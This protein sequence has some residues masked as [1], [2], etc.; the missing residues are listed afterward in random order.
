MFALFEVQQLC[1]V[2]LSFVWTLLI[3]PQTGEQVNPA[4]Q[5]QAGTAFSFEDFSQW[6]MSVSC[7]QSR[8]ITLTWCIVHRAR[9]RGGGVL[10]LSKSCR[11]CERCLCSMRRAMF[12]MD[13]LYLSFTAG[14]C[15]T[16]PGWWKWGWAS[17]HEKPWM[18]CGWIESNKD[19]ST[20]QSTSVLYIIPNVRLYKEN[21]NKGSSFP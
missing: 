8:K 19:Y 1:L 18:C 15:H 11:L 14:P 21:W 13:I 4:Q 12:S 20:A 17:N 2:P 9:V 3:Y 16:H 6:R 5:R 7:S 10:N